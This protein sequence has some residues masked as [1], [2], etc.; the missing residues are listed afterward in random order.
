MNKHRVG[1]VPKCGAMDSKYFGNPE[2][3][4]KDIQERKEATAAFKAKIRELILEDP[5]H[6]EERIKHTVAELIDIK[7]EYGI[8]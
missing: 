7:S 6:M 1:Q 3:F 4:E 5:G 2:Q 8:K